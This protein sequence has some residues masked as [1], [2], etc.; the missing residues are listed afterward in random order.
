MKVGLLGKR[1]S[2]KTTLLEALCGSK[3]NAGASSGLVN[4]SKVW[5]KDEH[6][7]TLSGIFKP[8]KTTY[9]DF[10]L[11]DYNRAHD[12]SDAVLGSPALMAKYRELD[13]LVLV[14]GVI[15]DKEKASSEIDDIILELNLSD[16][17]ILEAK[18]QR[19][20]KGT[21]DKQEL[22]LYE[23]I[24][25]KLELNQQMSYK[26]FTKDEMKY[27]SCF[28]L[29]CIKPVIVAV[30]VT[31]DLLP[32]S[33]DIKINK[34]GVSFLALSAEIEK[35]L[36]SLGDAEK[37]DFLKDLNLDSGISDRFIKTLYECLDLISFYTVGE[38]EVRAWSITRGDTALSAAGKIHSDIERGFIKASVVSFEDFMKHGDEKK[39]HAA[40]AVKDEGKGYIVHPGD[41]IHFKFNV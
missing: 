35:E 16:M 40:G 7:D 2:G 12:A 34:K 23:G 21:Y 11:I 27:L 15:S 20:K 26:D 13:A 19:M 17:M 1:S 29:F 24:L 28:Q 14:A 3:V 39:A 38:D 32:S 36:N 25:S 31:E 4:V 37:Q 22:A 30:N 10:D 8:K 41:I 5:V 6:I 33:S 18:I 9:A